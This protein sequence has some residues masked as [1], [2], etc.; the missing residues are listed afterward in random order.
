MSLF[1]QPSL[2]DEL[3]RARSTDPDTSHQ[4][5]ASLGS[6][7]VRRSQAEVLDVLDRHGPCTDTALVSF[8]DADFATGVRCGPDL[9]APQSPSGIRTRRRELT[10]M[11]RVRDT[12]QRVRLDSGRMATVWAVAR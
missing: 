11:G 7:R 3:P 2:F 12:G 9:L 1:D 8:Y 5:A 10:E 6:D 4:A